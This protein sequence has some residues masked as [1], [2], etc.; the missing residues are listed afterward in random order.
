MFSI[1]DNIQKGIESGATT[2]AN[3]INRVV[4]FEA[5]TQRDTALFNFTYSASRDLDVK[6]SL[7]S[8]HRD[9]YNL[10]SLN[11]GFSNTIESQVPLDDR[12]TDMIIKERGVRV[13][14]AILAAVT[15]IALGTGSALNFAL[16]ILHVA[17]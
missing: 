15:V 9:G 12:T 16:S 5:R 4:P 6:L 2:L 13:G 7:R 14:L 3:V 1:D 8:S 10:Q 11:F 17:F